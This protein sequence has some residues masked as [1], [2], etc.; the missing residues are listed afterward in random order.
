MAIAFDAASNGI[1]GTAT[2]WTWAHTCTGSDRI[3]FVF[4][5]QVSNISG[6]TYAGVSMSILGPVGDVA[7]W[8]LVNPATGTNNVVASGSN[9]YSRF[10]SSSYTGIDTSRGVL[11]SAGPSGNT[12]LVGT[13]VTPEANCWL[14]MCGRGSGTLTAGA[15]TIARANPGGDGQELLVDSNG[16]RSAGSNSVTIQGNS[17]TYYGVVADFAPVPIPVV[18][19]GN[20]AFFM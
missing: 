16:P 3:L 6:V 2:S 1:Q 18:V 13:L 5:H 8:Y 20:Y 12:P 17:G 7:L 10:C 4:G 14:V 11:A 19:S 15:N 9:N